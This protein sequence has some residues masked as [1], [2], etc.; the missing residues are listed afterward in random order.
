MITDSDL[1]DSPALTSKVIDSF[2]T[3]TLIR[4]PRNVIRKVSRSQSAGSRGIEGDRAVV[5]AHPAEAV[6][7]RVPDAAG[8]GDVHAVAGVAVQ[9]GQVDEQRA[10]EVA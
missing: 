3:D 2:T 4:V 10:V 6:D 7:Q 9:V 8:G 5:V 1:A